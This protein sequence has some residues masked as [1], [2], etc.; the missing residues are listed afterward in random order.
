MKNSLLFIVVVI[1]F[2]SFT[3]VALSQNTDIDSLKIELQKHTKKDTLRVNLLY[4]IA[5]S[6]FQSDL[7]LTK[8]Y[9][10]EAE[11]L[12]LFMQHLV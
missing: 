12:S 6:S 1:V 8:S 10:T 11:T 4:K 3:K 7:E 9:L 2:L 5:F